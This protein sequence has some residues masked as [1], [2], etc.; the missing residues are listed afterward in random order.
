VFVVPAAGAK[1]PI[2]VPDDNWPL[3]T[4]HTILEAFVHVPD[5][6]DVVVALFHAADTEQL[7][8]SVVL[9]IV[10]HPAVPIVGFVTEPSRKAYA[11]KRS[12]ILWVGAVK[13]V[14]PAADPTN[15]NGIH[16][17]VQKFK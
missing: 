1:V 9:V 13:L 8:P 15:D 3:N 14:V 6:S 4:I 7:V 16:I 2:G 5:V 11:I 10:V 17:L 12:P